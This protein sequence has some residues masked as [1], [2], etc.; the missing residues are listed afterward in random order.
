M[1]GKFGAVRLA[2]EH[3]IPLIAAAS[4]G[5]QRVLPRWSKR[6]SLFPRK[7]V[8][9]IIGDEVDLSRW[10]GKAGDGKALAEAT[11]VVMQE[12]T[13]LVEQLRGERAPKGPR[14]DPA[15]HGQSEFGRITE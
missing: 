15:E 9:V 2:L 10:K 6:I 14:W 1:R 11:E 8:E 12:I 4:W 5:A 3:D 7:D 13:A